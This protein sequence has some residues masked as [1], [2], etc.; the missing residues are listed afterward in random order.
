MT[1]R[2]R[3]WVPTAA[4]VIVGLGAFFLTRVVRLDRARVPVTRVVVGPLDSWISTNGVIEPVDP[5]IIRARVAAFVSMVHVVEGQNVKPNDTLLTL[6]V[7][8]PRA[9][10]AR[11]REELAK[12]END[13]RLD[14][15]GGPAGKRAQVEADLKKAEAEVAHLREERD[16]LTRLVAKESATRVELEQTRLALARAEA[17]R[18][19][20]ADQRRELKRDIETSIDLHRLAIRRSREALRVIEEQV[21]SATVRAPVDGIVY[22]LNVRAGT[23]VD[24]GAQLAAVADLRSVQLRAFVDEAELA[25]VRVG[26]PVEVAWSAVP[27]HTWKGRTERLPG[28]I[29]A[30]GDRRVGEIICSIDNEDQQLIPNLDVDVRIR[31]AAHPHTLLAPRGA[32]RGD[33]TGRYVFVV[34]DQILRRQKVEVGAANATAYQIVSG[35]QEGDVLA[36]PADTD[37]RDGMRVDVVEER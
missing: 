29:T 3:R 21:A 15:Q 2:A 30:R 27:N 19:A 7:L 11:A 13:L 20:L 25:P 12:A 31:L 34:R 36:L 17:T 33:Q 23:R 18:D 35:L 1:T 10:L 9:E 8:Q 22:S 5:H 32:V 4:I 28:N 16:A 37:L 24:V 26:Q 14:E 6:D